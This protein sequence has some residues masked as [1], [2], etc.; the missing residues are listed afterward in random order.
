KNIVVMIAESTARSFELVEFKISEPSVTRDKAMPRLD[1]KTASQLNNRGVAHSRKGDFDRAIEDYTQAIRLYPNYDKAFYNRGNAYNKK[2]D[3]ERAIKDYSEAIRI[4]PNYDKAFNNRGLIHSRKGAH[5]RAIEDY[6]AAIRINPNYA[7]ALNNRGNVF[8]RKGDYDRA[9]QDYDEAI[10]INPQHYRAFSNRGN[11]HKHQQNYER[12][13]EDYDQAIRLNP[14][15]AAA[16]RGRGIAQY[17]QERPDAAVS[18]FAKAAEFQP[19]NHYHVLW[20]FLAEYRAGLN[21]PVN[22]KNNAQKLDLDK[23]PGP[24]INFYL[25]AID[26]SA[27]YAAA[28]SPDPKILRERV[29]EANFYVAEAKLLGNAVPDALPLLRDAEKNCPPNFME[30]HAASA[31]L[32][33]LGN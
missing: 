3:H 10:R 22:L 33:R 5:D 26:E 15:Y 24:V 6:T 13:I 21:A 28:Q 18:D 27:L 12:A 32:K 17:F 16:Y 31:E 2:G 20:L 14:R 25:G 23:W 29:C 9:I 7:L 8:R 11:A 19:G 4:N 1:P 30:S